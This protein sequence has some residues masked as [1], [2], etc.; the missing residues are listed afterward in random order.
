MGKRSFRP[1]ALVMAVLVTVAILGSMGW[2]APMPSQA[3]VGAPEQVDAKAITAE[4]DLVKGKL[5]GFGL[6]EKQAASRVDLLS[7]QEV[8]TLA[9]NL[10][11]LQAA[12]ATTLTTEQILLLLILV[13]LVAA[14]AS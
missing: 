12:G 2:A 5:M 4:R 14:V 7:D 10:D 3:S 13:V 11:K 6:T 8:H 9:A 1:L